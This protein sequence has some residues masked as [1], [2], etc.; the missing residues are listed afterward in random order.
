MRMDAFIKKLRFNPMDFGT[1]IEKW[2][3]TLHNN[4]YTHINESI[5]RSAA[6]SLTIWGDCKEA[7]DNFTMNPS[8]HNRVRDPL[9]ARSFLCNYPQT[10]P[11]TQ[12]SPFL[13]KNKPA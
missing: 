2:R 10:I 6:F 12:V 13:A 3:F 1:D 8:K 7:S 5:G 11:K 9:S 4:V